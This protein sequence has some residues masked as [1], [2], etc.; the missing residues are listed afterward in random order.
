LGEETKVGAGTEIKNNNSGNNN[1]SSSF[2]NSSGNN[3]G[4]SSSYINNIRST[5]LVLWQLDKVLL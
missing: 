3:N 2:S 5:I 4:S 1:S